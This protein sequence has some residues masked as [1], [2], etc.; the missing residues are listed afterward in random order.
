MNNQISIQ[1]AEVRLREI[2]PGFSI[3]PNEK[4]D[5]AGVYYEGIYSEI[6]MPKDFIYETKN[7]GH[8]DSYGIPHRGFDV[9]QDRAKYF[10]ERIKTDPEYLLD[11]STPFD[12]TKLTV[13]D[14]SDEDVPPTEM[15]LSE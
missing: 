3:V 6:A 7:E 4:S 5:L 8:V 11:L 10:L 14:G 13:G 9:V 12:H 2:H 15:V 1:E